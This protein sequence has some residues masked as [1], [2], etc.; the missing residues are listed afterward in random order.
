M[1]TAVQGLLKGNPP[2]LHQRYPR[3]CS[4]AMGLA[5]ANSSSGTI[6]TERSADSAVLRTLVTTRGCIWRIVRSVPLLEMRRA[7]VSRQAPLKI[8]FPEGIVRTLHT[9]VCICIVVHRAAFHTL[10]D[11]TRR[12]FQNATRGERQV[13]TCQR[14]RFTGPGCRGIYACCGSRV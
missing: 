14:A 10:S 7:G 4:F 9:P 12:Q 5:S 1:R 8:I 6:Q 13:M 3:A 11:Q 2:I